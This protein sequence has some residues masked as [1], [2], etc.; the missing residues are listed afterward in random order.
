M[1]LENPRKVIDFG[2]EGGYTH[3]DGASEKVKD[4]YLSRHKKRE[5]WDEPNPGSA[6]RWILWNTPDIKQN[7]KEYIKK[8]KLEVPKGS[9]IVL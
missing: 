6:S 4:A 8:M 9:H 5:K 1:V 7:L 2:L 3:V